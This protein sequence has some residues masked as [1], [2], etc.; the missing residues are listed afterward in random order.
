MQKQQQA[1][2]MTTFFMDLIATPYKTI[3][4]EPGYM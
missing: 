4:P 1:S 3:I 2:A